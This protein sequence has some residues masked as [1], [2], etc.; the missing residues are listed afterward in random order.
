MFEITKVQP[1]KSLSKN[2]VVV[3]M[4]ETL[5]K[6]SINESIYVSDKQ[7]SETL[8]R[9]TVFNL[10]KKTGK[11]FKVQSNPDGGC[12]ISRIKG[13]NT[14]SEHE[15]QP[16]T[17]SSHIINFILKNDEIG[18]SAKIGSKHVAERFGLLL[19]PAVI[20]DI[21]TNTD[22]WR[23]IQEVYVPKQDL[24]YYVVHMI[25]YKL[26]WE[27]NENSIGGMTRIFK[28]ER[29]IDLFDE[30]IEQFRESKKR[31]EDPNYEPTEDELYFHAENPRPY[32]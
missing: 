3:M 4:V 21:R 5:E 6:L 14:S 20:R 13:K 18:L 11:N 28:K 25:N 2:P 32:M 29:G 30:D 15:I 12:T 16:Y 1:K 17:L 10:K 9:S 22:K 19:D 24:P 8:V 31:Q 26:T 23:E 7:V 27:D